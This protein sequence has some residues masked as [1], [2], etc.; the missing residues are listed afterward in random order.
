MYVLEDLT[1]FTEAHLCAHYKGPASQGETINLEC[2]PGRKGR[3]VRL[4]ADFRD[5]GDLGTEDNS[6]TLCEVEVY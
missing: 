5:S 4:Q 2:C 1:S 6:L 3:Y